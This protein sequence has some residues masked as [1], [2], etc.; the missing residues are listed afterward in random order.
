MNR[1]QQDSALSASGSASTQV[2]HSSTSLTESHAGYDLDSPLVVIIAH[3]RVN[4]GATPEN[5]QFMAKYASL[6]SAQNYYNIVL[7]HIAKL[8]F[9]LENTPDV[10]FL[11]NWLNAAKYPQL[12]DAITKLAFP[13][14]FWFSGIAGNRK[15]NPCLAFA[16]SLPAVEEITLAFHT[17]GL[18][19]SNW[20]ERERLRIEA[21]DVE[22]S[23][24]LKV[25]RLQ[26]VIKNY[27]LERIFRCKAL[28]KVHLECYN[29]PM[30]QYFTRSSEPLSPFHDLQ[31]WIQS[32]FMDFYGKNVEV[33]SKV[34]ELAS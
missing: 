33:D 18:T 8:T 21:Y 31:H 20:A 11:H 9:I 4:P 17:A 34:F 30:V 19:T 1:S 2:S 14:L 29:S 28:K 32:G 15:T 27:D 23:K 10:N 5:P 26:D 13:K 22:K 6:T 25:L 3:E 16:S 12:R 24:Q 7:P